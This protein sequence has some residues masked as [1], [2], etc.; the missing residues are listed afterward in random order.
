VIQAVHLCARFFAALLVFI[1]LLLVPS[2]PAVAADS[3]NSSSKQ[4]AAQLS[5]KPYRT[6]RGTV[7]RVDLV[8]R[9]PVTGTI[10][11]IDEGVTVA[12]AEASLPTGG[13]GT[14]WLPAPRESYQGS[15]LVVVE[16]DGQDTLRSSIS[17]TGTGV[18]VSPSIVGPRSLP[19]T[20]ATVTGESTASLEL[21]TTDDLEQRTWILGGFHVFATTTDE[22]SSLSPDTNELIRHWVLTGGELVLDDDGTVPWLETQPTADRVSMLGS[23]V[24]R[25]TGGTLRSGRWN[26]VISPV[27]PDTYRFS[28][29]PYSIAGDDDIRSFV[30]KGAV[31]LP[32]IGLLLLGLGVYALLVGPLLHIVLRK[33]RQAVRIWVFGPLVSVLTTVAILGLG[34]QL[35]T[36]A[37]NRFAGLLRFDGNNSTD[38]TILRAQTK[39]D[40]YQIPP[41]WSVRSDA[42]SEGVKVLVGRPLRAEIDVPSGGVELVSFSGSTPPVR[43]PIAA[44][45]KLVAGERR[46]EV[47]NTSTRAVRN[48]VVIQNESPSATSWFTLAALEPGATV[49]LSTGPALG[50]N[51]G[52]PADS[53]AESRATSFVSYSPELRYEELV[54]TF[55]LDS[56]PKAPF[57]SGTPSLLLGAV[58]VPADGPVARRRSGGAVDRID[59]SPAARFVSGDVF[60][61]GTF[62]TLTNEPITPAIA[63]GGVVH[64]RNVTVTADL[65]DGFVEGDGS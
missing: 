50:A 7:V 24:I 2:N 15:L 21:I 34:L 61:D 47:T 5:A 41:G 18:A 28:Y 8:A 16:L 62:T 6:E 43:S 31:S 10:E 9:I 57:T 27:V 12:E 19:G 14:F 35:R 65:T 32:P 38:F 53:S 48:V 36:Q 42:Q 49:E 58:V 3:G 52:V 64:G 4:P 40:L 60:V 22:L 51:Q 20:A 1:V 25:R 13:S 17:T 45:T 46:L 54:V 26:G 63:P 33:K 44:Q 59:L 30:T 55:E 37:T 23:G 39:S 56:I 29:S 11:V